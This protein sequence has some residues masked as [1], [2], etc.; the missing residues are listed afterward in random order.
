MKK[1]YPKMKVAEFARLCK[2]HRAN[3]YDAARTL[4]YIDYEEETETTPFF[5]VMS[6][7]TEAWVKKMQAKRE[8]KVVA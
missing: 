4:Q 6:P 3:V 5:I 8:R 1:T 2:M 7:K